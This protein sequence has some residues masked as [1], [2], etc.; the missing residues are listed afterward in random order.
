MR[1]LKFLTIKLN[2]M[3]IRFSRYALACFQ[4]VLPQLTLSCQAWS[5][6]LNLLPI[7]DKNSRTNQ[8]DSFVHIVL[9]FW[10]DT[11]LSASWLPQ[12]CSTVV[13]RCWRRSCASSRKIS[14]ERPA[15]NSNSTRRISSFCYQPGSEKFSQGHVNLV[16]TKFYTSGK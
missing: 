3:H 13:R 15:R 6:Q 4:E 5:Y 8:H 14:R 11:E 16:H 7:W 1:Y 10:I 9:L 12:E 2:H